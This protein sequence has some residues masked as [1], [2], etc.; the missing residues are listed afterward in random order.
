MAFLDWAGRR[1]PN[2]GWREG[3]ERDMIVHRRRKRCWGG[4]RERRSGLL[5]GE[6]LMNLGKGRRFW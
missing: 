4:D 3:E 2:E 1:E 6:S 5:V